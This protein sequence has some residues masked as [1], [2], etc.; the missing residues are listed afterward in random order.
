[1]LINT[2]AVPHV[3]LWYAYHFDDSE[4]DRL[5]KRQAGKY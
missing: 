4:R 1:M 5:A 2:Q 3:T